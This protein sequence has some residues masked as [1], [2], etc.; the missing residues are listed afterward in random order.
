[1]EDRDRIGPGTAERPADDWTKSRAR[2]VADATRQRFDEAKQSAKDYASE[3][4]EYVQGTIQQ[5]REYVEDTLQQAQNTMTH[6]REGGLAKM[7]QDLAGYTR[8]QPMTAL[9]IAAG[10]GLIVGWLSAAGRR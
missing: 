1:M 6:Y 9:L 3:A 8:A 5:T 7:K 2:D 10:A 4:K